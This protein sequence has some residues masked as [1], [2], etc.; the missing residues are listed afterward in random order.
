MAEPHATLAAQRQQMLME[1]RH[2]GAALR[3]CRA[4]VRVCCA[5]ARAASR[6][7]GRGT[8]RHG[9]QLDR[10]HGPRPA[11]VALTKRRQLPGAAPTDGPALPSSPMKGE[12]R[13]T[14]GLVA[15]DTTGG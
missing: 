4:T 14:G 2:K 12:S 6:D 7:L 1:P 9:A 13:Q 8:G 3:D 15:D 11:A 10:P 5:R